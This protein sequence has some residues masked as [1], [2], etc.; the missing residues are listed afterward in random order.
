M[1]RIILI[2][3]TSVFFTIISKAETREEDISKKQLKDEIIYIS[4]ETTPYDGKI[5]NKN[6]KGKIIL[7][8]NYIAGKK[9]EIEKHYYENEKLL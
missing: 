2:L 3:I 6:K 4:E 7:E 9:E 1:K 8:E 5:I